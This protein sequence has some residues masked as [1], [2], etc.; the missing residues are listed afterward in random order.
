MA[1]RII[2]LEGIDQSGKQTQT[3]L[4]AKRLR[5]RDYKTTTIS[6]PIYKSLSG[7]RIRAYLR[8]RQNLPDEA[9]HMLYSLNRWENQDLI[10]NLVRR[11]DFVIADRYT[12]SN[13]AYGTSRGLNLTWLE[14]LDKG[15]P[16]ADLVIVLDTP[17]PLSFA[18]KS[19]H[20]DVYESDREFLVRVRRAYK[21]LSKRLDWRIV[22]ASR[23]P[24]DVELE[25]WSV[26]TNKFRMPLK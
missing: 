13:L 1:A 20:R 22:S 7:K 9:V 26:V 19:R 23:S 11:Y 3:R 4:L 5:R 2:A 15:L 10:E 17:V 25:I 18:R 8:G 14:G 21:I 16:S 6:F 24:S 12:P